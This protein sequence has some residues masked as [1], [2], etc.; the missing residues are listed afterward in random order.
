M[1]KEFAYV[2]DEEE[3]REHADVVELTLTVFEA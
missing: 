1:V 3:A 2:H